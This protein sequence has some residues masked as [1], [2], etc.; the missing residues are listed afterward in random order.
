M[1][2]DYDRQLEPPDDPCEECASPE[3]VTRNCP[4]AWM[5]Y[6]VEQ[7]EARKER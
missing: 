7:A 4:F 2:P 6:L 5:Q 3:H 1:T